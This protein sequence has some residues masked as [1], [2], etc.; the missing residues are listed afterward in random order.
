MKNKTL[1]NTLYSAI[2]LV[3][4]TCISYAQPPQGEEGK[5]PPTVDEIFKQMD[6]NKDGKLSKAEIKG[7]LKDVFTK[8]DTNKDGF[9]TKEELK[10]APK[11]EGR[12]P[13]NKK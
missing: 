8:I 5:K 10:K 12:K 1:K 2:V 9:L 3:A 13:E 6:A 11:P 4:G 7:P